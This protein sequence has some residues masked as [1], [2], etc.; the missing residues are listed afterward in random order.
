MLQIPVV[1]GIEKG[2]KCFFED[3]A[4]EGVFTFFYTMPHPGACLLPRGL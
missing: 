1:Y 2:K 4:P 3:S